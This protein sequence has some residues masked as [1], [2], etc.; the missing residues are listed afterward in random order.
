[1]WTLCADKCVV[2]G[3]SAAQPSKRAVPAAW[4][5]ASGSTAVDRHP[6]AYVSHQTD[7]KVLTS[8]RSEQLVIVR[9]LDWHSD[10]LLA[11]SDS[12]VA[13]GLASVTAVTV[14][15]VSSCS[16]RREQLVIVRLLDWHSDKLLA[17]SDSFV[18]CGLASVT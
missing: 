14:C 15:A 9:L 16:R 4:K 12:F 18:A 2:K 11:R 1:M 13:C 5:G 7:A 17:R 6:K 8:R 3:R 10:K